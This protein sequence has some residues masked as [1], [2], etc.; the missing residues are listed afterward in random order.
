MTTEATRFKS[1]SITVS[2]RGTVRLIVANSGKLKHPGA[3]QIGQLRACSDETLKICVHN[4]R[5]MPGAK[6]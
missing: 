1:S 5:N 6:H 3:G 4:C 2:H